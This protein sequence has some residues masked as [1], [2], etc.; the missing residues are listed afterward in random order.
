MLLLS[1]SDLG[2]LRGIILNLILGY[3]IFVITRLEELGSE[4]FGN[5]QRLLPSV[6]TV[7]NVRSELKFSEIAYKSTSELVNKNKQS[8][9]CTDQ[10]HPVHSLSRVDNLRVKDVELVGDELILRGVTGPG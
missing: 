10:F 5:I 1:L 4:N 7:G 9:N 8:S 3:T 2:L 6:Q